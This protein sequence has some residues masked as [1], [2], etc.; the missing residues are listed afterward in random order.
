M[1]AVGSAIRILGGGLHIYGFSVFF[2]PLSQDLGLSRTTTSLAFSLARAEGAIEGPVAGYLID[3]FGPRPVMVTAVIMSGLGYMLLSGVDSFLTFLLVYM[4]VISLSFPSGFMHAP[5]VL[6]NTWLIRRR[7]MAMTLT[8]ASVGLGGALVAPLLAMAVH[9]LGWR[10]A[11]LL[12]GMSLLIVGIPLVSSVR[13]SP[14]SMGLLPDGDLPPK[15]RGTDASRASGV[16]WSTEERDLTVAQAM[17]SSAYWLL[18]LATA[19]RVAC[20]SSMLVHFI[21]IMVWKGISEQRAALMLGTFALLTIPTHFLL[22][23]MADRVSKPRLMALGMVIS[24][25]TLLVLIYG[26]GEW[27]L[28]FFIVLLTIPESIFPVSWATVGDFFG[29]RHFATIRGTMSFFYMWG[30]V[31]GPVVAGA[32]YDQTQ[33]YSFLLWGIAVLFLLGAVLYALLVKPSPR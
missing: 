6:A 4:G 20:L 15:P 16:Q 18:I 29:R 12:A 8:S 9:A 17:R 33:S 21:P 28:W 22:G 23:W 32:I 26:R 3:R 14:E 27:P 2:L 7:A 30:T 31:A 11:A 13:R 10:R 5:M 25:G 19:F 1:I 24:T